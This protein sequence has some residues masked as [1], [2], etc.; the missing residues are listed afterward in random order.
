MSTLPCSRPKP[1]FRRLL[2]DWRC[3]VVVPVA[4]MTGCVM[5]ASCSTSTESS[6]Q[7]TP[8]AEQ[9]I[10]APGNSATVTPVHPSSAHKPHIMVLMMENESYDQII[11]NADAPY[12]N[13][14]AST[15]LRATNS[16]ARGHYSLPNYL[17]IISGQ[18]YEA[19]GT[20]NDCTP[21]SCG[22]ITGT[23]VTNQLAAAGVGW[24]AFMGAMPSDCSV[25][26]AGGSGGYGVR[27]DPFIYFPQGRT[28]PACESDVPSDRLLT[29]LNSST[30]PDF[31]FYSPSICND[32][33]GDASCSTIANGDYF[34]ARQI[35][36]IMATRWYKDG[37]TIIIT[38]DEG[39]DSDTSGEHGDTGGHV[40]TIVVSARTKGDSPDSQY[41]DTAGI[42]RT[43]ERA[44][45][46]GYLGDAAKPE[47]GTLPLGR[48]S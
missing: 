44:Y 14:I 22:P 28:N 26:N 45:G 9:T 36:A 20:A 17:E 3:L 16:Y 31:V 32:G 43:I 2:N 1:A 47:S 33:G 13:S 23:N 11:G 27:H 21:S 25:S 37:G 46:L 29:M 8:S 12:E 6:V 39:T 5:L 34:L 15:Y 48:T 30:P 18:A 7:T 42:L 4:V 19:S 10:P 35:P 40:L 41:V 24:M 38:W